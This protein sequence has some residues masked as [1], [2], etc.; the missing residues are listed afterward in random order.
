[1]RV[2][3]EG[4]KKGEQKRGKGRKWRQGGH[5]GERRVKVEAEGRDIGKE[6]KKKMSCVKAGM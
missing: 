5:S 6:V 3:G 4:G 2:G 1:M